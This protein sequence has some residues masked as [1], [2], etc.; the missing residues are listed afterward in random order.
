MSQNDGQRHLM[1]VTSAIDDGP[2]RRTERRAPPLRGGATTDD[3]E[4]WFAAYESELGKYLIQFVRDRAL[5]EDLIQETFLAAYR[6]SRT[7]PVI[8]NPRAWLF[9][10]ARNEALV[11]LRRQRRLD[12]AI[13]RLVRRQEPSV[14][15]DAKATS[16]LNLLDRT[17]SPDDRAL[18][19]LFHL[20]GFSANEL[21]EMTGR[22]SAAVR[23][24]LSR[25][26]SR[27]LEA[28]AEQETIS[29]AKGG[30]DEH[31]P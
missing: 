25:A 21:S 20:H 26:R 22:S 24:R 27:L 12:R 19:L 11:A 14:T 2:F 1:D 17:L 31:A 5:A 29:T 10:I 15:P 8:R 13:A 7:A 9:G 16:I 6:A 23:Q 18:V 28:A 4:A 3:V 30:F